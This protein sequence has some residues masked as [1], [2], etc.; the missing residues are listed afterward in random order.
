MARLVVLPVVLQT[1]VLRKSRIPERLVLRRK[2]VLLLER[3]RMPEVLRVPEMRLLVRLV[4]RRKR[5]ES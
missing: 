4:L 5:A 1:E 3:H 2:L